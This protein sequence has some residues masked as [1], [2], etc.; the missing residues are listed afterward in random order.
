M[1]NSAKNIILSMAICAG[2]AAAQVNY[3]TAWTLVYDGGKQTN[4][5]S[6]NDVF[7]DVKAL[8]DG[9][10]IGVGETRDSTG[11]RNVLLMRLDA[12]GSMLWKK[13]Y[14]FQQGGGGFSII[15]AKN[16]DFII[17]GYRYGDPLVMR[18]DTVGNIRWSTW[19]YDSVNDQSRLLRGAY[20]N[21]V[22]ETSRGTIICAAGDAYP[23]NGGQPL[24]SYAAFLELDSMGH[25]INWGENSNPPGYNI[26]GF[27]I[28]ETATGNYLLSG[29]QTVYYL[30]TSG[31][32]IWQNRYTFWLNGVGTEVNN[33]NRA[34][35]L[36]S[37]T[38]IVAGQAYE[39]NCWVNY[40]RLYYDAWWS[41]FYISSGANTTW[42]T[43]GTQGGDDAVYDFTQLKSGNLVFV[44]KRGTTTIGGVWAFVTDSTGANLLWEKQ[45]PIPY[46]T[47][48]GRAPRP[49]S[50]CATPDSGF[51]VVGEYNCVDSIG[52]MNAFA[53]HFILRTASPTLVSPIANAVNLPVSQPLV[54]TRVSS[55]TT[56][57]VQ[58]ATDANFTSIFAQD[59]TLTDTQYVVSGLSNSTNYYWRVRAKGAEGASL[60]SGYRRFTTIPLPPATP[61]LVSPGNG[62]T[63]QPDPLTLVWSAVSGAA[64]Y[65]V[66]VATDTGFTSI[67]MRDST[68]TGT[69]RIVSGMGYT[70]TYYWR[71]RAKNAAG[72]SAWSGYWSFT[73]NVAPP[74]SPTLVLPSNGATDQPVS[75]TLAWTQ[76]STAVSYHVQ[77]ATDIGFT[78]IVMQDSTVSDTQRVVSGLL[79]GTTYY[80][81]VRAKNSGGAV[82]PWASYRS[83]TTIIAIPGQAVVVSPLDSAVIAVDS[84]RLV[85]NWL[86]SSIDRYLVEVSTDTTMGTLVVNDS[87]VSD[88][89]RLLDS[90]ANH[91][92]YYWRVKAHNAA[93]WG[94]YSNETRFVTLF[95]GVLYNGSALRAFSLRY[96]LGRLSYTLLGRCYVSVRYYDIRGRLV[97]SYVNMVQGCGSYSVAL[98]VSSW[99]TGAYVQVFEAGTTIRKD[100]ILV[101]K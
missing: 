14:W 51:T 30:D 41:P 69:Q 37:G 29:N 87:M 62:A 99:S 44:G 50:V 22:R 38:Y 84:V 88:T 64:T 16:G 3:D 60:W 13:L 95:V 93:G 32:V 91:T 26:G 12:S 17:G 42:D 21:C 86:G 101:V 77:V 18:T 83:F 23:D 53:A 24:N 66:Q 49:L 71:V 98:P 40:N 75:L 39:G 58:V 48:D 11:M 61:A 56:Y 59:S 65:Y 92:T 94:S 19:Y 15:I 46:R 10:C 73:T 68:V 31:G 35:M 79:N 82:S 36:R 96:S 89:T 2:T 57:Y 47:A 33:V 97:G 80:W 76:V 1:K 67:F 7:H 72:V 74:S 28:E 43:A 45:F 52:G 20:V 25:L 70:T 81:R 54:W 8:P 34:K 55:A 100:R 9:G 6:I 27:D 5:N 85:W 63:A 4:G 78:S 90:L